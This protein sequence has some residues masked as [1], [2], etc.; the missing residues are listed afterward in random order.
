MSNYI[1]LVHY[2][3]RRWRANRTEF[4][5]SAPFYVLLLFILAQLNLSDRVASILLVVTIIP[6]VEVMARCLH[7]TNRSGWF[8]L[9]TWVM[10]PIGRSFPCSGSMSRRAIE[11]RDLPP[12]RRTTTLSFHA[13][14]T[15]GKGGRGLHLADC[16]HYACAKYYHVPILATDKEFRET[17]L[18]TVP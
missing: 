2:E 8:Q 14:N 17:D 12:A 1:E 6:F 15:Y 7:G 10:P 5:C 3:I 13:A 18:E 16:I 11:L 4:G 9:F